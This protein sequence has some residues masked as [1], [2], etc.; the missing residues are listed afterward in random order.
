M[1]SQQAWGRASAPRPATNQGTAASGPAPAAAARPTTSEAVPQ[2]LKLPH[3]SVGRRPTTSAAIADSPAARRRM[4]RSNHSPGA[5]PP[6]RPCV[7]STT[8]SGTPGPPV[9]LAPP[10]P[11]PPGPAPKMARSQPQ[12]DRARL[13]QE[14]CQ[15]LGQTHSLHCAQE[16]LLVWLLRTFQQAFKSRAVPCEGLV[17]AT[18]VLGVL[19][20]L[21]ITQVPDAEAVLQFCLGRHA[22]SEETTR[23]DG[24]PAIDYERF[25]LALF[26]PFVS[27]RG[28]GQT[29]QLDSQQISCDY[30]EFCRMVKNGVRGSQRRLQGVS[31]LL[32]LAVWAVFIHA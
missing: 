30:V 29:V 27:L 1:P 10:P 14:L 21:G 8:A 26:P 11:P 16:P 9:A 13:E 12:P 18:E 23:S 17:S 28:P 31:E 24:G 15:L 32:F 6:T 4:D 25:V 20:S 22:T 5:P 7:V 19:R 3:V 2:K